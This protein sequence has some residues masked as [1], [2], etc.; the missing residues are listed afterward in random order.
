MRLTLRQ[1]RTG[2][3][4]LSLMLISGG[5]GWKLKEKSGRA[6]NAV[7]KADMG[8]FW[9]VWD[10]LNESYLIKDK[11]RSQEM[12]WGAIK[13]MTAALGDPYTVFLPPEANKESKED[14]NGAFEGVGIELGFKDKV[15][16]VVAPLAGMPAETAGIKAGDYI[17]HIKDEKNKVDQDTADLSLPEAVKLIRGPKGSEVELTILREGEAETKVFKLKRDTIIIKSVEL[18][19]VGEKQNYADLKLIKFGGRTEAEWNDAV[20]KILAKNLT[21]GVILDLRNNPG[22]YLQGAIDYASEFLKIGEV[23]V[24]QEEANGSV[25]TYSVKKKGRLLSLPV[26]ILVNKGSASSSEILAGSLRDHQR[27]KLIGENTFGKGTIQEALDVGG[28][29]GL[30]VTTAKWLLPSG[31]W[32]NETKGIKPEIEVVDDLKTTKDEQLE[33]AIEVI[34]Q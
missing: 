33:K 32:I 4:I 34:S 22:G 2:I 3:I 24:K 19:W 17:L 10:K 9:Q 28:G 18:S 26:V 21:K 30:H 29:A 31:Q 25:E 20:N 12:V 1:L 14:L 6:I 13:G 23:V 7:S 8:L 16:A 27:A 11:L 5:I 15:L